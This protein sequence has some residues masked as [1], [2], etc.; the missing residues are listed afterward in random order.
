MAT[1]KI[2]QRNL[3]S[4]FAELRFRC[5][6]DRKAVEA[7][8]LSLNGT[9]TPY[10]GTQIVTLNNAMLMPPPVHLNLP[11]DTIKAGSYTFIVN[12]DREADAYVLLPTANL[13]DG[14]IVNIKHE[15]INSIGATKSVV[16][17]SITLIDG[18]PSYTIR[19]L[20]SNISFQ[21]SAIDNN[22]HII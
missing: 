14:Q 6:F 9:T 22:W 17:E 3:D 7:F 16:V 1:P 21:Y 11:T 15:M 12:G 13:F 19:T 5:N 4:F 18:S 8:W 10:F 2:T 20:N